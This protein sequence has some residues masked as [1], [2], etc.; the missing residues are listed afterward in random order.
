MAVNFSGSSFYL[1]RPSPLPSASEL[2]GVAQNYFV[3]F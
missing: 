1:F 3:E 2:A